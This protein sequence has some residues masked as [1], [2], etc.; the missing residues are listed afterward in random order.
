MFRHWK[1]NLEVCCS[2]SLLCTSM[3]AF[4]SWCI[5]LWRLS[6][7]AW[8]G[9]SWLEYVACKSSVSLLCFC[10]SF[11][12]RTRC[13]WT[14][15]SRSCLAWS[16]LSFLVIDTEPSLS[17]DSQLLKTFVVVLSC[18][19][20][21][22]WEMVVGAGKNRDQCIVSKL[23][24]LF[25]V[26]VFRWAFQLWA[27]LQRK[28]QIKRKEE[29]RR[30]EMLNA[31]CSLRDA[32]LACSTIG[33]VSQSLCGSMGWPAKVNYILRHNAFIEH[34]KGHTLKRLHVCAY[35]WTSYSSASIYRLVLADRCRMSSRPVGLYTVRFLVTF[36]PLSFGIPMIMWSQYLPSNHRHSLLLLFN[37]ES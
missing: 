10:L 12:T 17:Y 27:W 1:L 5:C 26:L 37:F 4:I 21:S 30:C 31:H 32:R 3:S 13:D 7:A 33:E 20:A 36:D 22:G 15:C 18:V 34:R 23:L 2:V 14:H 28:P 16:R 35:K 25:A 9:L 6:M 19:A 24:H 11:S 29:H 8:R